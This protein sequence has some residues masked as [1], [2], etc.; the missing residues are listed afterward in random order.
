M[1]NVHEKICSGTNFLDKL[2]PLLPPSSNVCFGLL[3]TAR[4]LAKEWM[5]ADD[6]TIGK[7]KV[8]VVVDSLCDY[9]ESMEDALR[10]VQDTKLYF[11]K[12]TPNIQPFYVGITSDLNTRMGQHERDGKNVK[13]AVAIPLSKLDALKVEKFIIEH[14]RPEYNTKNNPNKQRAKLEQQTV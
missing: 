6:E 9:I 12:G 3:M 8:G 4:F 7:F 2:T 5:D 10:G 1:N 14:F 11:L 13:N